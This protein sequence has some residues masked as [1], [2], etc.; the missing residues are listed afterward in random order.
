[1]DN[2]FTY[3]TTPTT[4]WTSR[5]WEIDWDKK[6]LLSR[7][8][9]GKD[10]VAQ[11]AQVAFCVDYQEYPIFSDKFGLEIK[12]YIGR[13]RDFVKSNLERLIK[14]CLSP[15]LRIDK[16]TD[17]MIEDHEDSIYCSF[18]L[19]CDDGKTTQSLEVPIE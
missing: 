5:T 3:L 1:M 16:L 13:D 12:K 14:E 11:A 2:L 18:V 4:E 9:D 19:V 6:R 7:R 8:I 10:A 15:D 17:F